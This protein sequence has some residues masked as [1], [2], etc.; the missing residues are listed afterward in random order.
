MSYLASMPSIRIDTQPL[1]VPSRIPWDDLTQEHLEELLYCLLSDSGMQDLRWRRGGRKTTAADGG[2]DLEGMKMVDT[3]G[4]LRPERWWIEAKGRRGTVERRAVESALL[5]ARTSGEVDHLVIA[6]NS[7]FSNPTVDHVKAWQQENP[8]PKVWL[9]QREDL[10][11]KVSRRSEA[12]SRL[13]VRAMSTQGRLEFA[14]AQFWRHARCPS[15]N[16]LALFWNER[17]TLEWNSELRLAVLAG[18]AAHGGLHEHAWLATCSR[19]EIKSLLTT[20]IANAIPICERAEAFG[21]PEEPMMQMSAHVLLAATRALGSRATATAI[22]TLY[23]GR[24]AKMS[25]AVLRSLRIGV[26]APLLEI[27]R[28]QLAPVCLTGCKR[29]DFDDGSELQDEHRETYWQRFVRRDPP[30]EPK[31][32]LQILGEWPNVPCRAGLTLDK[33]RSCPMPHRI[34]RLSAVDQLDRTL[35]EF[36]LILAD[37]V[38]R[39]GSAD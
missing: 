20:T 37:I 12:V 5:S 13:F 31:R 34:D 3:M 17:G 30:K 28:R 15:V 16:E 27:A 8:R 33:T 25:E 6:T 14:G 10:E 32:Y 26:V 18:E 2:R 38:R 35:A 7:Q 11:T 19:R 1:I 36:E 29:V 9:W 22:N 4:E 24:G 39:E 21:A 23:A